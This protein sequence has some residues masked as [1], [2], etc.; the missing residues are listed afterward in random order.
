MLLASK[1][2]GLINDDFYDESKAYLESLSISSKIIDSMLQEP[3]DFLIQELRDIKLKVEGINIR[4]N[5][6][7]TE[8]WM[9]EVTPE[10]TYHKSKQYINLEVE[11]SELFEKK[12]PKYELMF[13]TEHG[14]CDIP[15]CA[16]I[17]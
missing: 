14:L 11:L 2:H 13:I 8:P 3:K 6:D 10:L 4:Y 17:I 1:E 15:D 9:I 12:F 16:K 5:I 7:N